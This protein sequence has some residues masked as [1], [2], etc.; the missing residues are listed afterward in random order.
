MTLLILT[1]DSTDSDLRLEDYV[2]ADDAVTRYWLMTV[3]DIVRW[4]S[5]LPI[6]FL[7]AISA[8]SIA[9]IFV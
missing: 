5:Y 2:D 4:F 7:L 1:N 6:Y 9:K 8:I 3:Y